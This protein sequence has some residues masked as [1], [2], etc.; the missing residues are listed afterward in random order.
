MVELGA[1]AEVV[2]C[3]YCVPVSV[4][5]VW[6]ALGGSAEIL[7]KPIPFREPA[8]AGSAPTA[9]FT[10]T[11]MATSVAAVAAGAAVAS[12]V[13][14]VVTAFPQLLLLLLLVQRAFFLPLKK[15]SP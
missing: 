3:S 8:V 2:C 14:T 7:D 12:A 5:D 4:A 15:T 6:V 11:A 1:V 10:P 13:A 9:S